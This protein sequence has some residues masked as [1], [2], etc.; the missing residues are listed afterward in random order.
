MVNTNI[1]ESNIACDKLKPSFL[2]WH[3]LRGTPYTVYKTDLDKSD[4]RFQPCS[5]SR[6]AAIR[7]YGL[8]LPM[9]MTS[10]TFW[11]CELTIGRT[12]QELNLENVLSCRNRFFVFQRFNVVDV[13]TC[14]VGSCFSKPFWTTQVNTLLLGKGRFYQTHPDTTAVSH[15]KNEVRLTM[16]CPQH[17]KALSMGIGSPILECTFNLKKQL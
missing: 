3:V 4:V 15:A 5:L 11:S 7:S 12:L 1:I 8:N 2:Q 10:C 13:K 9:G 6:G 16:T 14:L 17:V